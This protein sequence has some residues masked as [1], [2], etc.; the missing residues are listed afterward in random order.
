[1]PSR[2]IRLKGS[3][4]TVRVK[5]RPRAAMENRS[6]QI[7]YLSST[8]HGL[9]P[10]YKLKSKLLA[11]SFSIGSVSPREYDVILEHVPEENHGKKR[12]RK[13]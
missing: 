3:P 10:G 8:L 7:S 6:V 11:E 9:D 5:I 13:Q 4:G 12:R 2:T 1:L